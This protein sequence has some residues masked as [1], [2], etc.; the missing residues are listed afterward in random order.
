MSTETKRVRRPKSE[1]DTEK[2][3]TYF[4][5]LSLADKIKLVQDLKADIQKEQDTLTASL[6]LIKSS[7]I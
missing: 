1:V 5:S 6:E 3:Q 2:I 4:K 7:N